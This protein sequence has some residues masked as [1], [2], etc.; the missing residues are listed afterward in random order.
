MFSFA[1]EVIKRNVSWSFE[2]KNDP[3]VQMT[4]ESDATVTIGMRLMFGD[5]SYRYPSDLEIPSGENRFI[6]IRDLVD[7][8]SSR[9]SEIK[10]QTS[11]ILQMEFEGTDRTLRT[12]LVNLNPRS[13]ITSERESE[14]APVVKDIE[15][16]SGDPTGGTI[17]RIT[18][19]NF[20]EGASVKF[21]GVPA[22]RSRESDAALIAVAPAH[23]AGLVDLEVRNGRRTA[24]LRRAFR[25]ESAGPIITQVTPDSGSS[26]GGFR[27]TIQGKNFVPG[28]VVRWN[29]TQL[30]VRFAGPDAISITAPSGAAGSIS[31]QVV[32]PD[33][34]NFVLPDAF[35]YKGLPRV[36]SLTPDMGSSA[37]GYTITVYGSNFDPGCSVLFGAQ[38]G[39][40]T[41]INSSALAA[42]V[43]GGQSGYVDVSVSNKDGD[44]DTAPS[45]FLYNDPPRIL[46]IEAEPKSIVR[47]TT[48]TITVK[49]ADPEAGPLTYEYRVALGP[50]GGIVTGQGNQATY[51]SPNTTGT[52]IIQVTVYDEHR[53]TAQGN[54]EI[55]VE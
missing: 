42:I 29:G 38:Y 4:N 6:R 41:F 35:T 27:V 13:G 7:E 15:P 32:N 11:G 22:L 30:A 40:T 48:S 53:A 19:E 17:V 46:N 54:L 2:G 36:S 44:K 20:G 34:K 50:A 3:I 8:I 39:Q 24:L 31:V 25:Y 49:A 16:K 10:D 12:Q 47:N 28:T 51:R 43:P 23:A 37:G 14:R 45:G 1:A 33:D 21:G 52:A 5:D 55:V 9:Y 26:K 18:G